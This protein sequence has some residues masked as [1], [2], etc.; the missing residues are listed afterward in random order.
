MTSLFKT[1]AASLA[2][3][4]TVAACGGGGS[5]GSAGVATMSAG[6]ISGFGSVFVNNVRYDDSGATI[7]NDLGAPLSRAAL[8][9][10]A[11]VTVMGTSAGAAGS[12]TTIVPPHSRPCRS[13]AR[14]ARSSDSATPFSTRSPKAWP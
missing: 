4:L 1:L 12:A 9:L 5:S 13:L 7:T 3:A 8:S 6:T 2:A 10:G 11:N 14:V